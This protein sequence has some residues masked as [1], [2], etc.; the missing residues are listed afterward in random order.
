MRKATLDSLP[1]Q[2]RV[3]AMFNAHKQINPLTW[4]HS[5]G[6]RK[7]EPSWSNILIIFSFASRSSLSWVFSFSQGRGC[8]NLNK[9]KCRKTVFC[10]FR[11]AKVNITYSFYN[12][13]FIA[14]AHKLDAAHQNPSIDLIYWVF[15]SGFRFKINGIIWYNQIK[16]RKKNF[17]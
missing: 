2:I 12:N 3:N 1:Q 4:S 13:K 10:D 5:W 15:L 7:P 11:R 8:L 16:N 14:I 17:R 6:L 9:R